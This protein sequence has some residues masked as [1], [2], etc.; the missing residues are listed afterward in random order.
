MTNMNLD[1][2][3]LRTG[4]FSIRKYFIVYQNIVSSLSDLEK[5]IILPFFINKIII[6]R[7]K[8]KI[9]I[10]SREIVKMD[11]LSRKK[12]TKRVFKLWEVRKNLKPVRTFKKSRK[13]IYFFILNWGLHLVT[14]ALRLTHT[15][16]WKKQNNFPHLLL[17]L[18]YKSRIG[19]DLLLRDRLA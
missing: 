18:T 7:K 4:L 5:Q 10:S 8:W 14:Y 17:T 12:L 6:L 9:I 3:R 13:N 2:L 11:G 1:V 15:Y 19:L 16:F